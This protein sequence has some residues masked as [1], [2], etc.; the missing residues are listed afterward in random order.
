MQPVRRR[1]VRGQHS[2]VGVPELPAGHVLLVRRGDRVPRLHVHAACSRVGPVCA[3]VHEHRELHASQLPRVRCGT[4]FVLHANFVR[5]AAR[6]HELRG[7]DV[8]SDELCR[9]DGVPSSLQQLQSGILHELNRSSPV[10][11]LQQQRAGERG[12]RG[13]DGPRDERDV[14]DLLQRRVCAAGAERGHGVQPVRK[15][16]LQVGG[17]HGVLAVH[18]RGG[19]YGERRFGVL[20]DAGSVQRVV[21]RVPVGLRGRVRPERR[22]DVLRAMYRRTD[23]QSAG[24]QADG[25]QQPAVPERVLGVRDVRRRLIRRIGVHGVSE[26]P[27]QPVQRELP[28]RQVH[29]AVYS[30]R[31]SRVRRVQDDVQCWILHERRVRRDGLGGH[32]FLRRVRVARD[33]P[34][35]HVHAGGPVPREWCGG[36]AVPV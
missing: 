33:L 1:R 8:P 18:G 13:L 35:E 12:V 9:G 27:V 22:A 7:R 26:Y 11:H 6:V 16:L 32:D 4:D 19:E 34:G 21:E 30:H 25:G 10:L 23:L 5:V 29:R 14:P 31:G 2:A 3:A 15:G 17:G 36:C 28:G 20:A 24:G